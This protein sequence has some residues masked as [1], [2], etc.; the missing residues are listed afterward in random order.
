MRKTAAVVMTLS[1][2]GGCATHGDAVNERLDP[3]TATTVTILSRPVELFSQNGHGTAAD[4]FAYLAPFETN[5]QGARA[6]YLWVSAPVNAGLRGEPEIKCNDQP[7]TLQPVSAPQP[8]MTPPRADVPPPP[9]GDSSTA[10]ASPAGSP[11]PTAPTAS[12]ASTAP[13]ATELSQLYLSQAPYESPVPWSQQWYFRLTD[14]GLKCLAGAQGISL[15]TQNTNGDTEIY[16]AERK[17]IAAL[18]AFTQ[19]Y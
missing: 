10:A 11:A 6:L 13:A 19:H 2:L 9:A 15:Q 1:L 14:E 8:G 4:P 18:D 3:N 12:T 5:R 17:N 16:S 7:L